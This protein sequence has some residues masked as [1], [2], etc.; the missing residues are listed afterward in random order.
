MHYENKYM[1]KIGETKDLKK[2]INSLIDEFKY[3]DGEIILLFYGKP[4]NIQAESRIHQELREKYDYGGIKNP[5]GN[6]S[7]EVY[8]ISGDLY[9]DIA[10]L[11]SEET[12]NNY[13]ESKRYIINDNTTEHYVLSK[14]IIDYFVPSNLDNLEGKKCC[15]LGGYCNVYEEEFW[16]VIK[17]NFLESDD[18]DTIESDEKIL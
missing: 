14:N 17:Y 8:N 2:R 11:F 15:L 4:N 13:F 7:Y 5:F 12:R 16:K 6:K 1:I 10:L 3:C 9:D 18:K